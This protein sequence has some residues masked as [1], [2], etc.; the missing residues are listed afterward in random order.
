MKTREHAAQKKAYNYITSQMF[1]GFLDGAIGAA[2]A[3]FF[4]KF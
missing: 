3:L 2:I 4:L 1:A